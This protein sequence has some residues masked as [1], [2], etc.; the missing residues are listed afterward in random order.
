MVISKNEK[1]IKTTEGELSFDVINESVYENNMHLILSWWERNK[2]Y[3]TYSI[4]KDEMHIIRSSSGE[5]GSYGLSFCG[6]YV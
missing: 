5:S 4:T 2:F 3:D 6:I 1:L